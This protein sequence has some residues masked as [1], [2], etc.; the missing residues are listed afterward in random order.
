MRAA[1]VDTGPL[2]AYLNRKDRYHAWAVEVLADTRPP[3]LTCEAVL[4]EAT[5]LTN[6]L[7]GGP[8]LLSLVQQDLI[9]PTFRLQDDAER[10]GGL[11]RR[12]ASVPMD[13]ADAC[14]VRM[15]ESHP[16]C[17]LLTIDSEFRD[18]YRRS[19]RRV[20]PCLLPPGVR[21]RKRQRRRSS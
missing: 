10:V 21:R 12:Y 5:F 15:S 7:G 17:V 6:E 11:L 2:V 8:K 3:L 13:L 4:S 1:L 16:D 9:R 19:D 14:M 20:I 18:I